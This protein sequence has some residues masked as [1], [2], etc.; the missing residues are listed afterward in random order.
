MWLLSVG[1]YRPISSTIRTQSPSWLDRLRRPAHGRAGPLHPCVG[2]ASPIPIMTCVRRVTYGAVTVVSHRCYAVVTRKNGC[3]LRRG[4]PLQRPGVLRQRHSWAVTC[5]ATTTRQRRPGGRV[6]GPVR[7]QPDSSLSFLVP[8]SGRGA[9][10]E[11][12]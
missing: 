12:S 9:R 8:T 1:A 6:T 5:S 10:A 3:D 11:L 7:E 4:T 2:R